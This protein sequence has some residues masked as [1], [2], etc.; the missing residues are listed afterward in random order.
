MDARPPGAACSTRRH[1][2]P[3][4]TAACAAATPPGPPPTTRSSA[5]QA[6][7]RATPSR[8]PR[9]QLQHTPDVD[10]S[11]PVAGDGGEGAAVEG[12]SSRSPSRATMPCPRSSATVLP[13]RDPAAFPDRDPADHAGDD[14]RRH[15]PASLPQLQVQPGGRSEAPPAAAGRRWP[16]GRRPTALPCDAPTPRVGRD[17]R[18]PP[19]PR[20]ASRQSRR[21]QAPRRRRRPWPPPPTWPAG[22]TTSRSTAPVATAA[23]A[24]PATVPSTMVGNDVV[25]PRRDGHQRHIAA[26]GRHGAIGAITSQ[27]DD[28]ANAVRRHPAGALHRVGHRSVGFHRQGLHRHLCWSPVEGGG[29]DTRRRRSR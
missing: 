12:R 24:T 4:R 5:I 20:K 26:H 28:D 14:R 15:L 2:A 3:R 22:A 9:C 18:S 27:R 23:A 19:A 7:F 16:R 17:P 8:S 21:R 1:R 29:G 10:D 25:G 6:P 11:G 13:E